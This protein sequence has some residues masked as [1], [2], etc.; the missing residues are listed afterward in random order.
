MNDPWADLD[1]LLSH[2][3]ARVAGGTGDADDPFRLVTLA[4]T[5]SDG[6]EARMVALRRA[7]RAA[8]EVEIHS[9]LRTA[10]I[11]ALRVDPRAAILAWDPREQL[12]VRLAVRMRVVVG[13]A[14][15]WRRVP[16]A[17]QRNYG[18]DPAPGTVVTNPCAVRRTPDPD[19][20]AAL[21]GRVRSIDAV[22]LAHEPHRRARF[23]AGGARWV[24]P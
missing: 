14:D 1:T 7:D 15:R 8:G 12:Q 11:R 3:W 6:P 20:F 2:L 23:G 19:R 18:V 21:V 10:K 9:D 13:D 4:T 16:A 24:A 17:A 5:G 22:S